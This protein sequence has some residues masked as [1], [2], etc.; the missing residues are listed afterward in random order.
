MAQRKTL[1][2]LEEGKEATIKEICG[3]NSVRT[4]LI[5]MGLVRGI[6]VRMLGRAPLGDPIEIRVRGCALALRVEEA[7]QILIEE[8]AS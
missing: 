6:K 8:P 1:A 4:R 3:P 2:D 7:K 5:E